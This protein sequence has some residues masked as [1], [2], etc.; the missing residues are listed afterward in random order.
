MSESRFCSADSDKIGVSN[1]LGEVRA[2]S[3]TGRGLHRG[4]VSS[5]FGGGGNS[6]G[7]V[8]ETNS[9]YQ[10]CSVPN[11]MPSITVFENSR[12]NSCFNSGSAYGQTSHEA[13]SIT[14]TETLEAEQ[15]S[16]NCFSASGSD[17]QGLGVPLTF[18]ILVL[19]GRKK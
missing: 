1:K 19:L 3:L 5:E 17:D 2:R 9:N 18:S 8:S 10:V 15:T 12:P 14:S 7:K 4:E 6:T 11:T 13:H 16:S